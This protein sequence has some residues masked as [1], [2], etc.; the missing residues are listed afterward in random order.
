MENKT[1][2]ERLKELFKDTALEDYSFEGFD[3]AEELIENLETQIS[4]DEVIYYSNAME[5]LSQNDASLRESMEIADGMGYSTKDL[6]SEL[7]ATLLQQRNNQEELSK[8]KD[9]IE[10]IYEETE[11]TE[12]EE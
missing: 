5:Y 2:D 8:L 11:E 9:D 10:T 1:R 4:E 6:N 7:L 12:A 3:T